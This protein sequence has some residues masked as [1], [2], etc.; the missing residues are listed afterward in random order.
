MRAHVKRLRNRLGDDAVR[1]AWIF[2]E[3]GVGYR[4]ARPGEA[5]TSGADDGI[6][7]GTPSALESA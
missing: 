5:L 4:M 2:N 1:P 6:D 3:R 7:E